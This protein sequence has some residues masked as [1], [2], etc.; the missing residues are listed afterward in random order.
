MAENVTP[1]RPLT[2]EDSPAQP[3]VPPA[4]EPLWRHMVGDRLRQVRHERGETLGQ[5]ADRA[6]VS[7]QYLSEIERGVK[8]PSSEV[9]AAVGRAL[10][11]T[12][13]DLTVAV[14]RDLHTERARRH[15][16]SAVVLSLA[17]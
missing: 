10:G 15:S 5:T 3:A 9:I 1:I 16:S 4:R 12:L 6:G 17:A 8:E 14:A 11:L 13:L 7:P 2:D